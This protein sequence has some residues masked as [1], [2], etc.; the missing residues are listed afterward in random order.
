[1]EIVR[2]RLEREFGLALIT[3]LPNVEYH[4]DLTDGGK[5]TVVRNPAQMPE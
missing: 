3:T 2:E 1:M 4:A 5:M